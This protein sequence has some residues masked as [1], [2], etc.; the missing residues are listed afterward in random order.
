MAKQVEQLK[1]ELVDAASEKLIEETKRRAKKEI[2]KNTGKIKRRIFT[3]LLLFS[4]GLLV[5]IHRR[6]IKACVKGEPLPEAP[7][8]HFW[9]N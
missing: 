3:G 2:Q 8:W 5:G 6:V 7:A 4:A 9:C 1:A